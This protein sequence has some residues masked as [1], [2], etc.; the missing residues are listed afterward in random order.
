MLPTHDDLRKL[1]QDPEIL[2]AP[3]VYDALSA[4]IATQAGAKAI[5]LSGASIAYT[6]MARS[7]IG[8]TS[9]KEVADILTMLRDRLNTPI[10]VDGDDGFGNALNVQRTV[11]LF[12]R[13]GANAIQLE[14]QAS[15]KRCGH[16]AGKRLI[17]SAEMVGKIKAA[18][19]AR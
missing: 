4:L 15:P 5:Y 18:Q 3:G 13:A 11:R 12:E 19:D 6:H 7:D 8:L 2:V 16:L 14:D 17:S 1:L 10:I 9:M